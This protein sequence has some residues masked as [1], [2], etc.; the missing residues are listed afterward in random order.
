MY[1]P[2]VEL[3]VNIDVDKEDHRDAYRDRRHQN[4]RFWNGTAARWAPVFSFCKVGYGH[5]VLLGHRLILGGALGGVG[6]PDQ[7]VCVYGTRSDACTA[8]LVQLVLVALTFVFLG[9]YLLM[10]HPF[11]R[12]D[13]NFVEGIF[14]FTMARKSL[15]L[16]GST[17]TLSP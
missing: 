1:E 10:E 9:V 5:A 16:S 13:T 8:Q 14:S 11:L 7:G 17:S 15:A 12:R 6:G 2:L 3:D 4:G